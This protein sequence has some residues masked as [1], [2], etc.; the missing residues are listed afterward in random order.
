M[1][2]T[3]KIYQENDPVYIKNYS[4][5]GNS[6]IPAKIIKQTHRMSYQTQSLKDGFVSKKHADQVRSCMSFTNSSQLSHDT[7]P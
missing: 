1:S 3:L 5:G 6:W 2:K 7:R 4:T